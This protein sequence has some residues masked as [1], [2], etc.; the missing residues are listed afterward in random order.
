MSTQ[1]QR[2]YSRVHTHIQAWARKM[3]PEDPGPL[4]RSGVL[5]WTQEQTPALK[6]SSLPEGLRS[7][8]ESINSKLDTL[9]SLSSK[10]VLQ[11][12][13][14]LQL[15][16]VELSGAGLKCLRPQEKILEG[17]QLEAILVLTQF[18]VNLAGVT[19]QILRTEKRGEQELLALEFTQLRQSD[20]EKIVQFVFREQREQIRTLKNDD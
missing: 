8:L 1:E 15:Q 7:F 2:T 18:P 9:L 17:D 10:Q 12:D 6:D 3:G 4:F 16:V 5:T 20:R 11:G 19:G 13:F 14:P